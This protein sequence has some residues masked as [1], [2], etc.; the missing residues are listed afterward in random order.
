M[1]IVFSTFRS[2]DSLRQIIITLTH[3]F[4]KKYFEGDYIG[5]PIDKEKLEKDFKLKLYNIPVKVSN[6]IIF[7]GEIP[8]INDFENRDNYTI[9]K[10]KMI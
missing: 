7:L 10:M 9:N 3:C 6:N 5:T 8:S 2:K 1:Q 4:Y